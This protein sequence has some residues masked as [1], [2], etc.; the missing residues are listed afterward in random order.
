MALAIAGLKYI[1]VRWS[2]IH[3]SASS[4]VEVLL[5]VIRRIGLVVTV[6]T[7]QVINSSSW[8]PSSSIGSFCS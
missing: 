1:V 5:V 8:I 7:V 3:C 6:G 4:T 2:Q